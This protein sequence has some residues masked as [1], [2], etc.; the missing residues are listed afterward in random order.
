M[1]RTVWGLQT[2]Q[3]LRT[4]RFGNLEVTK[5]YGTL[6]TKLVGDFKLAAH[7]GPHN[8]TPVVNPENI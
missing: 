8:G 4:E 5:R 1:H 7:L 6:R 3:T 2:R